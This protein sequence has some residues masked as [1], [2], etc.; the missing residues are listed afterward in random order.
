MATGKNKPLSASFREP[1]CLALAGIIREE[2]LRRGWTQEELASRSKI[3]RQGINL[4]ETNQRSPRLDTALRLGR[5]FG[6]KGSGL[7]AR[8]ERR[9]GHWPAQC[10]P[11][12]Y[13]CV[14]LGRLTCWNPP[15]GCTRPAR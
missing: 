3:K 1:V 14:E 4:I 9:A 7:I 8:A 11:C 5:A 2:R 6:F 12:N 15:Q 10:E 13:C